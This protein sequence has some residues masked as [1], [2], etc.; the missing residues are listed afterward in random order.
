MEKRTWR[1]A[2][3]LCG[4]GIGAG[5]ASGQEL[6][7]FFARFGPWSW[8]GVGAAAS[9]M[10]SVCYGL[11]HRPGLAGMPES[12]QGHWPGRLWRGMFAGLMVTTGGAM[13]AA[14]GEIAGLLLHFHGARAMGQGATLL[15]AWG[16]A[17]RE[18]TALAQVSRVLIGVLAA[19]LAVGMFLPT[20]PFAS[21]E[22]SPAWQSL[23]LGVCYGGFNA[24]LAAP[25][26]ARAGERLQPVQRRRCVAV[27]TAVTALLLAWG[28]G[29]LLRHGG[30]IH[31]EL[32][33]VRLLTGMGK[34]GYVLGGAALYLAALTTLSACMK[35]LRTLLGTRVFA[36][37]AAL[38]ALSLGG[39]KAIVSVAYPIL[40][41]GCA[42]L[43]AL[44]LGQKM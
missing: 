5:L 14:G 12:W 43:L 23:P 2:A 17:Q 40:G 1:I 29:V 27:Y 39:M 4:V 7:A 26:M 3:E 9:V 41:G 31:Q 34:T 22:Q 42:L 11:M 25:L 16:L 36:G 21:L 38:A 33:F 13:L 20:D 6:A 10:G 24:A 37:S 30:L 18:G 32:P 35:N 28:N 44:A 15:L 8:L 19:V